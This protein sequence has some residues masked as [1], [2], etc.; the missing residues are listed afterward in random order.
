M[1]ERDTIAAHTGFEVQDVNPKY[2]T[3][4]PLGFTVWNAWVATKTIQVFGKPRTCRVPILI[5]KK[6]RR[7]VRPDQ[8][9]RLIE[10]KALQ[11]KGAMRDAVHERQ[12]TII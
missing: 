6:E 11:A 1:A 4:H 2:L 10:V 8:M 9:P 7:S 3:D 12:K 5:S